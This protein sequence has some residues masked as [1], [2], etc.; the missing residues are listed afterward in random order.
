MPLSPAF[1][2]NDSILLVNQIKE[3]HDPGSTIAEVAPKAVQARF[4]AIFLTSITTVL[5]L[6]PLLLETSL[7]AQVLIPLVTSLAFGLM[8]S[9]ILVLFVV[10]TFY[11]I[12][13]DFGL[14]TL[15][16]ERKA[17]AK[18]STSQ[19]SPQPAE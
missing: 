9:T 10:P 17:L 5:G 14:T 11:A 12:L 7:Q 2:V 15:A 19:S 4:R 8:A 18:G 1:V 6:L 16:Q 3:H 13:D